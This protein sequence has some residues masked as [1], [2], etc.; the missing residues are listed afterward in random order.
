[1]KHETLDDSTTLLDQVRVWQKTVQLA[2]VSVASGM[3]DALRP[4]HIR[5]DESWRTYVRRRDKARSEADE[6]KLKQYIL[7]KGLGSTAVRARLEFG[8]STEE[9]FRS[10]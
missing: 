1:M 6:A 10:G 5:E 9:F 4:A 7:D 3:Y 2:V 8:F